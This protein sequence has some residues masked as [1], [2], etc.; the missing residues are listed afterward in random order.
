MEAQSSTGA[1]S[2]TFVIA[3]APPGF[4]QHWKA[5][6]NP[7]RYY[8]DKVIT[9]NTTSI[10]PERQKTLRPKSAWHIGLRLMRKMTN[11]TLLDSLGIYHFCCALLSYDA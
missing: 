10:T 11:H 3:L 1:T 8:P 7:I 5:F 6:T 9:K 2:P 4:T